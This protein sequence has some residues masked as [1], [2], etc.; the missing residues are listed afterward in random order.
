VQ[1]ESPWWVPTAVDE[2]IFEKIVR[3]IERTLGEIRDDPQHPLR[4]RFDTALKRFID[5]LQH[6]PE[7][8]ARA[9][10]LKAELLDAEAVRRFSASLWVDAKAALVRFAENAEA[11][12]KEGGTI[13]RALTSFGDAV[14][15]DPALMQ[16]VDEFVIDIA[17]QM[18]ER[19]Q[20][21]I[22]D[23]ITHTVQ[24]WDA[25]VTTRRIELAIGRDLQ[26]IRINGTLVGALAGL[27]IYS[28]SRLLP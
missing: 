28:I 7:T 14:L 26:Y 13:E 23:L 5:N 24:N 18:V 12:S 20:R 10:E 25:D 16:R 11:T 3:S 17:A 19:Y 15:A 8:L 2:K 6:S 27:L 9:E 21:E 22:A 4:D 1:R